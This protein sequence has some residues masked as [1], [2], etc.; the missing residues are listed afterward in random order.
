MKKIRIG[1]LVSGGGTNLQA[2]MDACADGQINGEVVCVGSDNADAGGLERARKARIPTFVLPYKATI[3]LSKTSPGRIPLNIPIDFNIID[4]VQKMLKQ[5]N[6]KDA[7]ESRTKLVVRAIVEVELFKNLEEFQ[8]DVLVLAG[9]MKILSPYFLDKFQPDPFHPRVMN[10]H[11]A[12][13]PSFPGV[14][15]YTDAWNYG[16]RVHGAT[17][18]FLDYG[19]DTGPIIGQSHYERDLLETFA[20]FKEKG[21][22]L[23]WDL[24]VKCL[25]FYCKD[26]LRVEFGPD[27]KRRIVTILLHKPKVTT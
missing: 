21:L 1:A 6:F 26:L 13:L 3:A 20:S 10:I 17:V 9:F 14:D 25:K 4:C 22:G 27:G 11:P 24:Y 19:E 12:L 16:V 18:H 5:P 8:V 7:E 23:E 2:I 15:G